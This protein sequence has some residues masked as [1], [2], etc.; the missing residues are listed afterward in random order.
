[1]DCGP[2]EDLDAMPFGAHKGKPLQDV[3][4]SYLLWLW[5][6][7]PLSDSRLEG[8][9]SNSFTALKKECPDYIGNK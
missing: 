9:I 4:A 1:M 5:G 6:Q 3:P 8:Y 2:Y 7:R